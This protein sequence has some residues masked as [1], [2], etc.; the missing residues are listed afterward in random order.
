MLANTRLDAC[1]PSTAF[2]WSSGINNL[3]RPVLV[4]SEVRDP[5]AQDLLV[6]AY[7]NQAIK[8]SLCHKQA[9]KWISMQLR[10]RPGQL[11][12]LNRNR[13]GQKIV[14]QNGLLH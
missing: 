6:H 2:R 13:K 5:V 4:E 7:K 11:C 3:E 1:Y 14:R 8:L 9:V 10:K 12:L